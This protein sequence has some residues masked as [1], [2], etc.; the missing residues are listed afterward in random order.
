MS[1]AP[2]L[3][4]F[5]FHQHM[6]SLIGIP[7]GGGANA[8]VE[9]DVE[10]RLAFM[11]GAGIAQCALMPG[12]SYSAPRGAADIR[13][14]NDDL[15]AYRRH[16][17]DRFPVIAATVD[18]RHGDHAVAEVERLAGMGVQA[19]SWHNRMQGLPIDHAVMFA[20]VEKADKAGMAIMAHCYANGDFEA[21]WRLRRLAEAFPDTQ[22]VALDAMTSPENLE[23]ILAIAEVVPNFHLDMTTTVLG[24]DGVRRCLDRLGP[25]RLVFGTNYYSMGVRSTLPELDLV[26]GA[27]PTDEALALVMGGNARRILRLD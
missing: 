1:A 8:T 14:M 17:P 7:G 13:A 2:N 5:D 15:V 10:R 19:L 16:A 23:L 11:D 26:R 27:G 4:I 18:P 24:V 25:T 12:H 6:G 21:A 3:A 9:A 20:I 22:F